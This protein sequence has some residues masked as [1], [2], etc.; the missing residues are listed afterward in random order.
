MY[1]I[2]SI[3]NTFRVYTLYGEMIFTYYIWGTKHTETL[4]E[5]EIFKSIISHNKSDM[6]VTTHNGVIYSTRSYD[7]YDFSRYDN[8]DFKICRKKVSYK[9]EPH[10]NNFR[11]FKK[12]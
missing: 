2:N 8:I 4:E 5:Y 12:K 10:H 1:T 3:N 9:D 6:Y 11:M 7:L